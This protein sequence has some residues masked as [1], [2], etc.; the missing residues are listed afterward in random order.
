M[1]IMITCRSKIAGLKEKYDQWVLGNAETVGQIEG[2]L[3][4][5]LYLI[6]GRFRDSEL[7]AELGNLLIINH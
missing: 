2:S 1:I 3:R 7:K 4:T 5:F 6:P